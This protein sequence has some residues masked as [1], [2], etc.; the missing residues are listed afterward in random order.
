[1]VLVLKSLLANAG[2]IR[3][4]G[5]TPGSGRYPGEGHGNLPQ[6]SCLENSMNRG[7]WRATL[8]R[9]T[10]SRTQLKQH[11]THACYK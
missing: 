2:D 6:H 3:D 5:L 7:A 10:K 4:I 9:V 8:H 11:G 1:M